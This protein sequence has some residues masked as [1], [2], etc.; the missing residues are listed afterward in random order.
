MPDPKLR[1]L[2]NNLTQKLHHDTLLQT[3]MDELRASLDCDR[4][5]LYYFYQQWHGQVTFEALRSPQLSIL[6]SVGGDDC[7]N[8]TYAQQYFEGRTRAV[9]DIEVEPLADCHREFLRGLRVRANL[10]VPV[11]IPDDLWGLLIAHDQAPRSW[12]TGEI[13]A[14][15]ASARIIA[16]TAAIRQTHR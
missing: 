11:L 7:F 15:Q 6:G 13:A 1:R 4:I 2:L 5:V 10:V 14:M 12:Q 16:N 8:D 3:T 9:A